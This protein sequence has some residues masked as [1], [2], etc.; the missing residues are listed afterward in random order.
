MLAWCMGAEK[1]AACEE[2]GSFY[3]LSFQGRTC[4]A[5]WRG[6]PAEVAFG[7]E[8]ACGVQARR[9]PEAHGPHLLDRHRLWAGARGRRP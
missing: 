6:I 5:L 9:S 7:L 8:A 2:L 4:G 3:G 1:S